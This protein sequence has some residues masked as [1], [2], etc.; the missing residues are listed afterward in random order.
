MSAAEAVIAE[1]IVRVIGALAPDPRERAGLDEHLVSDLGFD[2]L[3][4]VELSF[5]I[6]ELFKLDE[7]ALGDAP[8]LGTVQDLVDFIA[9]MV[10][11]GK[12]TMPTQEDIEKVLEGL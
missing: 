6:E 9:R 5:T 12:A 10:R 1:A 7:S 8:S 2:S 3:R 11:S 4:T